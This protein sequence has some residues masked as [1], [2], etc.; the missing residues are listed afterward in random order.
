M[1]S[2]KRNE[3][4]FKA[5]RGEPLPPDVGGDAVLPYLE[6]IEQG[7]HLAVAA[8]A[9]LLDDMDLPGKAAEVRETASRENVR[10]AFVKCVRA[11][12]ERQTRTVHHL[13]AGRDGMTNYETALHLIRRK[14]VQLFPAYAARQLVLMGK[15]A[16]E[17][18]RTR[19]R[20]DGTYRRI[21]PPI[22]LTNDELG[23][24][25]DGPVTILDPVGGPDNS[26]SSI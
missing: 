24:A 16:S 25:G 3:A 18:I 19:L 12:M 2:K 5:L 10:D 8:L 1:V 21:M 23:P 22:P 6:A 13:V 7:D 20:E 14:V 11:S 9:D 17:F 4:I 26:N 15:L